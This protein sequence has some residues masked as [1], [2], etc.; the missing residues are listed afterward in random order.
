V[1]DL[2]GEHP[3]LAELEDRVAGDVA[4]LLHG[5]EHVDRE[6]L[7]RPVDTGEPQ[8]GVGVAR[9]LVEERGLAELTDLGAH[10]LA[11]LHRDLA[12]AGLVPALAGHVELEGEGRTVGA[13]LEV[14]TGAAGALEGLDLA[15]EDAVHEAPGRVGGLGP[16]GREARVGTPPGLHRSGRCGGRRTAPCG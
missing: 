16:I 9:R 15:D 4:E 6:A 2:V 11:E 10:V 13:G 14:P 8:H 3:V 7:E 12:V 1:G 5:V